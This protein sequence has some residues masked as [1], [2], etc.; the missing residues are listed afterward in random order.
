MAAVRVHTRIDDLEFGE[1]FFDHFF[2]LFP[3]YFE[4]FRWLDLS[5]VG[6]NNRVVKVLFNKDDF[7]IL[8]VLILLRFLDFIG[9]LL[10]AFLRFILLTLRERLVTNTTDCFAFKFELCGCFT[11]SDDVGSSP[12]IDFDIVA[13]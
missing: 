3:V 4:L 10:V 8:V 9:S 11:G 2:N 12:F 5:S 6:H 7:A 13:I 1:L